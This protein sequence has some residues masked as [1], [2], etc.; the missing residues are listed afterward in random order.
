MDNEVT[1]KQLLKKGKLRSRVTIIPLNKI[2]ARMM[3]GKAVAHAKQKVGA[4]N[5]NLALSLVGYEE[6]VTA[7]MKYVFGNTMICKSGDEAKECA[8][9]DKIRAR[10]ITLDGDVFDPSGT[11]TGGARSKGSGVLAQ[12]EKLHAAQQELAE[13]EAE[14][15]ELRQQLGVASKAAAKHFKLKEELELKT[16][17]MSLV[18]ARVEQSTLHQV[19]EEVRVLEETVSSANETIEAC[20]ARAAAGKERCKHL[21]KEIKEFSTGREKKIKEAEKA[22]E[23][24]KTAVTKAREAVAKATAA[25]Q[26]VILEVEA[27]RAEIVANEKQI[28]AAEVTIAAIEEEE[29]E[30]EAAVAEKKAEFDEAE[31]TL[32]AKREKLSAYDTTLKALAAQVDKLSKARREA[33]LA[34]KDLEHKRSQSQSEKKKAASTVESLLVQHPWIANDK[35]YFGQA[36]SAFDFEP[37][38]PARSPGNCRKRLSQLQ[39]NQEDLAK[40]VNMKVCR[41][42]LM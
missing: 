36:G 42:L 34:I 31:G 32:A 1:G 4:A 29:L 37:E 40:N 22:K 3:D 18:R 33:E 2:N 41:A 7:A 20:K 9:N 11:L 16:H 24:A 14:A 35:Q 39:S 38:D 15:A 13:L 5:A 6:D 19:M 8:F 21:E 10:S 17:E 25:S 28:A 12:L 26:E 30:L 27:L 23:K